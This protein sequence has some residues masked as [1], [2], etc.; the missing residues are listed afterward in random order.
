MNGIEP[1]A[2]PPARAVAPFL[3]TAPLGLTIAGIALLAAEPRALGHPTTPPLLAA[4]HGVVLGWMTLSIMGAT[5]QLVPSVLGGQPFHSRVHSGAALVACLL[6]SSGVTLMVAAFAGWRLPLLASGATLAVA[7]IVGYLLIV[8]RSLTTAR[9]RGP[10]LTS[11]RLA[12]ILLGAVA[13]AGL[14]LALS[15]RFGWF[16][17]TSG[18]VAAHA[19]LGIVGWLG[20]AVTGVTYRLL[21]MF[22]IV[23]GMEPRFAGVVPGVLAA[24]AAGAFLIYAVDP[25]PVARLLLETALALVGVAWLSDAVRLYRRRL[26]RR[27]D[28]YSRATLL[29]FGFL[30][31]ALL[32]APAAAVLPADAHPFPGPALQVA[33][34]FLL[35]PGWAGA[36]LIGNSYKIVPFI[37][38]YHRYSGVAGTRWTPGTADLYSSRL[39]HAVLFLVAGGV[40]SGTAAALGSSLVALRLAGTSFATAGLVA[41]GTLAGTFLV[42][43][44]RRAA[45]LSAG[46]TAAPAPRR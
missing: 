23:R 1:G 4:V 5:L 3:V 39:A 13:A 24:A 31:A 32:L 34:G 44:E 7:G 6:H 8:A 9:S 37:A 33:C 41:C 18:T 28:L 11:L 36:T 38:W 17:V 16:G 14:A 19:H 29:S 26:R 25:P 2:V 10:D 35:L 30:T 27:A 22:G 46:G 12:H 20:L 45:R 21:P 43:P 42:R 40:V 15:L